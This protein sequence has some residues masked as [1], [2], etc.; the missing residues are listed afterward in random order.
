VVKADLVIAADGIHSVA[1]TTVLGHPNPAKKEN[2]YNGCFRFLIPV[3]DV[4]ADPEARFW[5]EDLNGKMR[6]FMNGKT[7]NRLV[8][9]PCRR[10]VSAMIPSLEL[11]AAPD[12]SF[13]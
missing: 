12:P 7:G 8:S 10:Q 11:L 9:Y 2:L 1:T 13:N 3:E 4:E 6:I 5:N